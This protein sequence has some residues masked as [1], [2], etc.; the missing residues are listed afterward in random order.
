MVS[1]LPNGTGFDV[2]AESLIRGTS[3]AGHSEQQ[4]KPALGRR[5]RRTRRSRTPIPSF[6][7]LGARFAGPMKQSLADERK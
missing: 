6:A 5:T 3:V 2:S 1:S 4:E 7:R